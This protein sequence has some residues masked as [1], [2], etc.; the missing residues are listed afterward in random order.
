[1][2]EGVKK[3][4]EEEN[5]RELDGQNVRSERETKERYILNVGAIMGLV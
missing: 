1:M 2:G 5:M 3:G 4:K